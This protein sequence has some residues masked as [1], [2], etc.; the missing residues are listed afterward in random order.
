MI[1]YRKSEIGTAYRPTLLLQ[2]REGVM[3]V[4][5][6]QDMTVDINEIAAVRTLGDAMKVPDF[7][8]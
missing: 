5:L 7:V 2:L 8:E 1:L 6:V 3:G 4:Q